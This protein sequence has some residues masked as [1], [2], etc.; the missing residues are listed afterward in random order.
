[1]SDW[2][3]VNKGAGPWDF[4]AQARKE[5]YINNPRWTSAPA[6]NIEHKPCG[7][8]LKGNPLVPFESGPLWGAGVNEYG[9]LTW[10]NS[11]GYPLFYL[12]DFTYAGYYPCY[13]SFREN[14]GP[15][16]NTVSSGGSHSALIR[17]DGTLWVCGLNSTGEL[18]LGDTAPRLNLVQV[19]TDTDWAFVTCGGAQT[20][21]IKTNG[22]MWSTGRNTT[23]NGSPA[24]SSL[25]LGDNINRS[26]FTQVPGS[27]WRWV[28]SSGN[29][30]FAIKTDGTLW[31]TGWNLYGQLGFGTAGY[32]TNRQSFA[33]VGSDTDWKTVH[34]GGQF[35]MALKTNGY[36]YAAGY[37]G[38]GELG[39]ND[40]VE[41]HVLTLTGG[42]TNDWQDVRVGGHFSVG[43]KYGGTAWS[44]G[45]NYYGQLGL[46]DTTDRNVFTQI[47]NIPPFRQ[48]APGSYHIMLIGQDNS[49]WAVGHNAYGELGLDDTYGPLHN[50]QHENERHTFTRVGTENNWLKLWDTG[51]YVSSLVLRTPGLVEG[52]GAPIERPSPI[53]TPPS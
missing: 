8:W 50:D 31:A 28:T 1:M 37:N 25:G 23:D 15:Y 49:L 22:T 32:E 26:V 14:P 20:F 5:G 18:G 48:I 46:G 27:G 30:A 21:A 45:W 24:Y 7:Y 40:L 51:F 2:V 33:Q 35:T 11:P 9:Q 13:K 39:L 41:R 6:S 12:A 3:A 36:L 47:L 29:H 4:E 44:T 19:G 43:M 53:W 34:C 38:E 10:A 42:G 52:P 17:P 16:F